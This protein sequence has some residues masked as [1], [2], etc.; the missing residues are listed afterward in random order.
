MH[1]VID[2]S[3]EGQATPFHLNEDAYDAL[4]RYLGEARSRLT[5]PDEAEVIGDLERSIGTRLSERLGGTDR[6]LTL[7]DVEDVLAAVGPVGPADDRPAQAET[8]RTPRHRKL[9]RIRQDQWF[10]GVCQGLAAYTDI[11]VD[12]VRTIF[13]FGALATAGLFTIVYLAL[14]F[15]LP[16]LPTREAWIAAMEET[17]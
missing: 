13:I 6:I 17:S 11:G 16:V 1:R 14:A 3:L 15:I 7:E 12:W 4:S 8:G 10:A 9:Y 2:I 5:D